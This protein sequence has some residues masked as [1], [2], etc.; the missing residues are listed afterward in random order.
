MSKLV[1][2]AAILIMLLLGILGIYFYKA[3]IEWENKVEGYWN[4]SDKTSTL[5]AKSK[6]ID[7]MM[8]SL[9]KVKLSEYGAYYFTTINN[10]TELNINALKTLQNRLKE[11]KNMNPSSFEYQQAIQQI[12]AQEQGE[13]GEMISVLFNAWMISNHFYLYIFQYIW[14]VILITNILAGVLLEIYIYDKYQ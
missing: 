6:Y 11:I 9:R 10:K 5:E 7:E 8:V 1:A 3:T 13:A 2:I 4:L 12:T 14:F